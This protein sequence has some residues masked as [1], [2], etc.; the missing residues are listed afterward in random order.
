MALEMPVTFIRD[1]KRTLRAAVRAT[2]APASGVDQVQDWLGEWWEYE[3]GFSI[4][5]RTEGRK[6]AA[7]FARLRGPST[8][9]LLTD[10]TFQ[11]SLAGATA[12][13]C[14]SAAWLAGQIDTTGWA[15]NTA[16]PAGSFFN[17]GSGDSTR[18]YQVADDATA[19]AGGAATL[20]I[21]PRL[22]SAITVATPLVFAAPKVLLR[23]T[24][25]VPALIARP[26]KYTFSLSAKEAL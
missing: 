26:E 1:V 12:P 16:I 4:H 25:E 24:E 13:S 6:M 9:F 20:S 8:P 22:R 7:F 17:I 3:L 2:T 5:P 23:L 14:A 18:L 11:A 10:P 21:V 15:A 19:T